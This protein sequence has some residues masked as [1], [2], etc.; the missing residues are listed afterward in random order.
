[1]KR[2]N[3]TKKNNNNIFRTVILIIEI[4]KYGVESKDKE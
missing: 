1:M 2:Y 3:I 4:E